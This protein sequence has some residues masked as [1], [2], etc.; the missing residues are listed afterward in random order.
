M[1]ERLVMASELWGAANALRSDDPV[2]FRRELATGRL[3]AERGEDEAAVARVRAA[4]FAEAKLKR[5]EMSDRFH[6]DRLSL[7]HDELAELISASPALC[8]AIVHGR[9]EDV[10]AFPISADLRRRELELLQRAFESAGAPA[11][12]LDHDTFNAALDKVFSELQVAFGEDAFL[13]QESPSA[14]QERRYC[15]VAAEY[16]RLISLMPEPGRIFATAE[17]MVRGTE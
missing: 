10:A 6:R 14:A 9:A 3:L 11:E 7:A 1:V 2:A 17:D 5:R 13:I 8:W 12:P 4:L 16:T 15:E